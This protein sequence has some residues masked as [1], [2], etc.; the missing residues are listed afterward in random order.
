M[1]KG[2]AL[3]YIEND[4]LDK[5]CIFAKRLKMNTNKFNKS[6]G[7]NL[8]FFVLSLCIL[9]V[10]WIPVNKLIETVFVTPLFQY[11]FNHSWII[12]IALITIVLLYY[13]LMFKRIEYEGIFSTRR[14]LVFEI[15][16]FYFIFRTNNDYVFYSVDNRW[17]PYIDIVCICASIFELI[18]LIRRSVHAKKE[19][20]KSDYTSFDIDKPTKNDD[21][22]RKDYA[23][24]LIEKLQS[25]FRFA[26][27]DYN[28]DKMPEETAFTI[29]LSERYGQGKTSF[30]E[31]LKLCCGERH[32]ETIVFRPWLSSDSSQMIINYFNL[33]EEKI[34]IRNRRLKKLLHSYANLAANHFTGRTVNALLEHYK[35]DSIETQHD[36]I[37]EILKKDGKLRVVL[38]DDVDRLQSEEL[39]TVIKLIRNTADFPYMA[40]IVAA[41][42]KAI[43]ETLKNASIEDSELYLKKFFNF[44]L[45]FPADD[46]NVLEKLSKKIEEVLSNFGYSLD[47]CS[48]IRNGIE[49][50]SDYYAT[51][52]TNMRDVYRFCNILSFELDVLRN[53]E[54]SKNESMNLLKDLYITDFVKLHIIQYISLELYKLLRDYWFVLLKSVNNGRFAI[55]DEYRPYINNRESIRH[56]KEMIDNMKTTIDFEGNNNTDN[57]TKEKEVLIDSLPLVIDKATPNEDELIKY[58]LDDLWQETNNYM[59]LRRIC[60]R[61]QYFLYFSGRYRKDEMSDKEAG[62]LFGLPQLEFKD[63][64]RTLIVYKKESLI[65]KLK[66]IV[67]DNDTIDE[68]ALLQNISSLSYIDY[69]E[70]EQKKKRGLLGYYDFYNIQEYS[71]IIKFLY[72]KP[73]NK[74]CFQDSL[75]NAHTEYFRNTD[76]YAASALAIESMRSPEYLQQEKRLSF[77]FTNEQVDEFSKII[78]DRFFNK[79]FRVKPFGVA[80]IEAIPCMRSANSKY[81]D[82][83][84][85]NYI[86]ASDNPLE[87]LFRLFKIYDNNE[88]MY[89][90]IP[91]VLAVLGENPKLDSFY[92]RAERLVGAEL[93]QP[94][95]EG[96]EYINP[97]NTDFSTVEKINNKPF[98][99]AA[100]E[101][102]KTHTET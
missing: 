98:S 8:L 101:W 99:K 34:G 62:Q 64:V 40:Y 21:L 80:S 6:I 66:R 78:I 30:F 90:D 3:L 95:K 12:Q 44:E 28:C 47:E 92:E 59:D 2:D 61:S 35:Q 93:L 41:D 32:I 31:Q 25:T 74:G 87:W 48:E 4:I 17:P 77:V 37:S 33:L 13:T 68:V 51:V 23:I 102:L 73:H 11:V 15:M 42:K 58:L 43:C 97:N 39:L 75:Y 67:Q 56:I 46:G 84:F 49:K 27:G 54:L 65:H 83:L 29:L 72:L 94:F 52:F 91:M 100:Y 26:Q 20:I 81:W 38:I 69:Q 9:S 89:W 82:N 55:R 71:S 1:R 24:T 45:I 86:Q 63:R 16:V 85:Q 5:T 79:V 76:Q 88:G 19:Q 57:E 7:Y 10:F 18:L 53:A 60:Y 50:Y 22:K 36:Q 70:N 96:M 14:L